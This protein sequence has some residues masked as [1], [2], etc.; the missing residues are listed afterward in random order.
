MTGVQV[1]HPWWESIAMIRFLPAMSLQ[2]MRSWFILKQIIGM[3][4][5]MDSKWNTIQQVSKTHQF[6]IKLNIIYAKFFGISII[7]LFKSDK[8]LQLYFIQLTNMVLLGMAQWVLCTL[9]LELLFLLLDST[10]N[11][12][13]RSSPC[14]LKPKANILHI[15]FPCQILLY[16][17]FIKLILYK[18]K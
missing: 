6:K 4:I 13:Y 10:K 16:A 12:F 8:N 18:K 9:T 15:N 3:A 14:P 7:L 11:K 17:I 1:H 2:A 5:I